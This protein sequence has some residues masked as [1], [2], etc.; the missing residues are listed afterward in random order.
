MDYK[1][2]QL[3][4]CRLDGQINKLRGN[5]YSNKKLNDYQTQLVI[6]F[7]KL[8]DEIFDPSFS[9]TEKTKLPEIKQFLDFI[10]T[11]VE[12]LEDST[13]NLIPFETIFCLEQVLKE[14][15]S[16]EYMIVTSLQHST[17]FF[18]GYLSVDGDIY[19]LIEIKYEIVFP[20]QLIQISI[21]KS[22]VKD[23]LHNVV[24][25]HELGHFIDKKYNISLKII[26]S[27]FSKLSEDEQKK[28]LNDYIKLYNHY[29]EYFADIF[30]AQYIDNK[31]SKYLNYMGYGAA[32]SNSHPATDKRISIVEDFIGKKNNSIIDKL[33]DSTL[34]S[35]GNKLKVRFSKTNERDFLNLIPVN[36]TKESELHGLYVLGWN[37]WSNK[38]NSFKGFP[39]DRTYVV[40]NNLIEKSI[41]NFMIKELWRERDV[42]S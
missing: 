41:S 8:K 18:S 17:Y 6:L 5:N 1:L 34:H 38:E 32:D 24:L 29:M 23:Y 2:L 37:L 42:S 4:L 19:Q 15:T 36:I 20:V 9:S 35:T 22:E 12:F 21:P 28:Q 33:E 27:E 11:S 10:S 7:E 14:W 31:T 13:L 40:I 30:A 39:I 25:Y 26:N 3:H 16:K